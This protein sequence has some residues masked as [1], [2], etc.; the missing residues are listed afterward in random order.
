MSWSLTAAAR[1]DFRTGR[2]A[3]KKSAAK[4]RGQIGNKYSRMSS[5]KLGA[6]PKVKSMVVAASYDPS[7]SEHNHS[8]S[9]LPM[10][11]RIN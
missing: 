6:S 9:C 7:E 5:R 10:A 1:E 8:S 2:S 3:E 11:S 4:Q